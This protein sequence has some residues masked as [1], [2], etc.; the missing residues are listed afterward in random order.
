MDI[1][2][3]K[4]SYSDKFSACRVVAT[5]LTE[6]ITLA[7]LPPNCKGDERDNDL[8]VSDIPVPC[9]STEERSASASNESS[10]NNLKRRIPQSDS[11]G[12]VSKTESKEEYNDSVDG[13]EKPANSPLQIKTECVNDM[14]ISLFED[15]TDPDESGFSRKESRVSS[16][17]EEDYHHQQFYNNDVEVKSE[18]NNSRDNEREFVDSPV[19][20]KDIFV[21][22]SNFDFTHGNSNGTAPPLVS[23]SGSEKDPST[24][25]VLTNGFLPS[26]VPNSKRPATC[27]SPEKPCNGWTDPEPNSSKRNFYS[28]FVT[29]SEWKNDVMMNNNS[30]DTSLSNGGNDLDDCEIDS[31]A[32]TRIICGSVKPEKIES[33]TEE[34]PVDVDEEETTASE[35]SDKPTPSISTDLS[36]DFEVIGQD[37]DVSS[38]NEMEDLNLCLDPYISKTDGTCLLCYD[39]IADSRYGLSHVAKHLG[40]NRYSCSVPSC[41]VRSY[42]KLNIIEHLRSEHLLECSSLVRTMKIEDMFPEDVPDFHGFEADYNTMHSTYREYFGVLY[43]RHG[44]VFSDED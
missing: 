14:R 40:V 12:K 25:R 19:D 18:F 24:D 7:A 43:N 31:L 32:I 29:T 28:A 6:E 27:P 15:D 26:P 44:I 16:L 22:Q 38:D 4:E 20:Q 35:N 41:T 1:S 33:D 34:L 36:F 2:Y 21:T 37:Y 5:R 13:K 39:K 30:E 11:D 42:S 10:N 17:D 3:N 23:G 8:S 9:S